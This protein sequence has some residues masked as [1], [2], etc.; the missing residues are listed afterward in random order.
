MGSLL[1]RFLEGYRGG[2]VIK[3]RITGPTL[4]GFIKSQLGVIIVF[5]ILSV[6][7]V[8]VLVVFMTNEEPPSVGSREHV[9][10]G[11]GPTHQPET[12]ELHGS[13]KED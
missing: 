12:R 4:I 8:V 10:E 13:V 2:N 3:K 11:R 9:V 5:V 7:L 1:S 6:V